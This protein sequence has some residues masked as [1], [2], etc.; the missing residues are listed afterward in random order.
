[1]VQTGIVRRISNSVTSNAAGSNPTCIFVSDEEDISPTF[2]ID[3]PIDTRNWTL[4]D[5]GEGTA[6]WD[7]AVKVDAG[8]TWRYVS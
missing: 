1:M 4:R 7:D 5:D 2:D 3:N 8:S 6:A